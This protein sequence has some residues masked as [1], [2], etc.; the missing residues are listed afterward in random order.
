M[1]SK[2]WITLLL[3][4]SL[5]LGNIAPA[6]GAVTFGPEGGKPNYGIF[7]GLVD[8]AE[9]LL[10]ITLRDD[11]SHLQNLDENVLS[12][13]GG[14]WMATTADGKTIELTESQLPKHIQ[15][16][17]KLSGE[18]QPTTKVTAFVV[19]KDAPTAETYGSIVDVPAD[20]ANAMIAKQ[21]DMLA[22]VQQV[23]RAGVFRLPGRYRRF[24]GCH[25]WVSCGIS[26]FLP[27]LPHG[28]AESQKDHRLPAWIYGNHPR[29]HQRTFL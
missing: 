20:I 7:D 22:A 29:E 23:V 19:L 2:R 15:V 3:V 5:V 21:N 1:N 28:K 17:R 9:K 25:R 6:A 4:L 8:A 13:V 11:Q 12:L 27:D 14:K 16:L 18:L 24:D 26:G 10:G